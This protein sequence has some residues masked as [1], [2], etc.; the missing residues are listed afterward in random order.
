MKRPSL[1]KRSLFALS[2]A[3][4]ALTAIEF[5]AR[6]FAP[7]PKG[8]QFGQQSWVVGEILRLDEAS[9]SWSGD[10]ELLWRLKPHARVEWGA[11]SAYDGHMEHLSTRL[12]GYGW[13][14]P[15]VVAKA[16]GERRVIHLGDSCT[17]GIGTPESETYA[18][19]LT[20]LLEERTAGRWSSVN[21]GVPSYSS[22]QG[23]RLFE[24]YQRELAADVVTLYFGWNDA[25]MMSSD[26]RNRIMSPGFG[27]EA[28]RLLYRSTAFR[29]ARLFVFDTLPERNTPRVTPDEFRVN[30]RAMIERARGADTPVVL[31]VPP[32]GPDPR[33]MEPTRE[34]ANRAY[35]AVLREL[36]GAPGVTLV[37]VARD[38]EASDHPLY[39]HDPIHPNSAGHARIAALLADTIAALPGIAR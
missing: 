22:F 30:V 34:P 37:D 17:W 16:A 10:P 25:W 35:V 4:L 3:A 19:R 20:A 14:G 7:V 2:L 28:L 32:V 21:A 23:R 24:R 31:I 12:N 6:R 38:F 39:F 29:R 8:A 9:T 27:G 5:A 26:A 11:T 13:R 36:G 18:A 15:E 33:T 1:L